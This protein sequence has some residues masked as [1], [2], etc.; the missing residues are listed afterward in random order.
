MA[1]SQG[2]A[3]DTTTIAAFGDSLF[4]GY[5]LQPEDAFPAQLE[6]KL[7]ADGYNV[8]V[9]NDGISGDTTG[10]GVSRVD[11][12][13]AQRPDIVMLSLGGNDLLRAF[14][15]DVTRKNLDDIMAKIKQANIRMLLIGQKAPLTLGAAYA[16]AFNAIYLDLAKQYGAGLYPFFLEGVYGK[17][18]LMQPDGVHPT[19]EG[20]AVM[21]NNIYPLVTPG[22]KK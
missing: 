22:L 5:G 13:I 1:V 18:D 9:I 20:V 3:A 21:V 8:T 19:R 4:S 2:S 10:G 14:P 16:N 15:P 12:V 11:Q 17:A 6:R 7:K